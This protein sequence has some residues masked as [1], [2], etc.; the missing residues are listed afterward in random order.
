[1]E[2]GMGYTNL[3][4]TELENVKRSYSENPEGVALLE[5]GISLCIEAWGR[6]S[7]RNF[8]DAG[9]SASSASQAVVWRFL[10]T[11]PSTAHWVVYS[12]GAGQTGVACNL[13]RLLLEEMVAIEYYSKNPSEALKHVVTSPGKDEADFDSKVK[14][15]GIEESHIR[16]LHGELSNLCAHANAVLRGDF[17]R[18]EADGSRTVYAGPE[19][20]RDVFL[21]C[22]HAALRATCAALGATLRTFPELDFVRRANDL[23][24]KTLA[25]LTETSDKEGT[26]GGPGSP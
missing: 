10:A 5:E 13:V 6:L 3:L 20:S 22:L 23:V 4:A 11:L 2:T 19:Y 7:G 21:F 1:M 9:L 12:A 16:R 25:I 14:A 26:P 18:Q 17:T 8:L 15:L 24:Q